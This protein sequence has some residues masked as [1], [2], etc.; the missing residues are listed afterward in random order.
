[1]DERVLWALKSSQRPSEL[2]GL[3]ASRARGGAGEAAS[4]ARGGAGGAASLAR[5]G[6]GGAACLARGGA[7][8]DGQG[9]ELWGLG[10]AGN[11]IKV[12]VTECYFIN[13]PFLDPI[14]NI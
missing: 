11:Y 6:A 4:L 10:E 7:G 13:P 5:G 12:D 8:G 3:A 14:L 9:L 1:M 2:L